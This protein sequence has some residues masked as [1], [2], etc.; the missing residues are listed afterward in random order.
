VCGARELLS[1]GYPH[2]WIT[3]CEDYGQRTAE[4]SVRAAE[5]VHGVHPHC[6]D[7]LERAI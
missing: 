6:V 7:L 1:T 2:L 3:L 5:S 4:H